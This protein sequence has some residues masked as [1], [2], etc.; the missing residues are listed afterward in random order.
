MANMVL[1]KT[2][3]LTRPM[4]GWAFIMTGANYAFCMAAITLSGVSGR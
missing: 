3:A 2:K 4:G 1:A